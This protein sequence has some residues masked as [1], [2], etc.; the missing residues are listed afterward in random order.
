MKPVEMAEAA[1]RVPA[2]QM[3]AIRQA[4]A[5]GS[6]ISAGDDAGGTAAV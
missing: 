1:S 6:R 5:R 3:A 4:M 2:S